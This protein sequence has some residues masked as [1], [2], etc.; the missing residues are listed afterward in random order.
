MWWFRAERSVLLELD[1]M[2]L[3]ESVGVSVTPGEQIGQVI[4]QW[5]E[6]QEEQWLLVFDNAVEPSSI[7]SYFPRCADHHV[8]VTS[9]NP[10]WGSE[11]HTLVLKTWSVEQS[12][13]FLSTRLPN[14]GEED[15]L[16]M[17]EALDGLPWALAQAASYIEATKETPQ[18]Y[19][20]LLDGIGTEEDVLDIQQHVS[21]ASIYEHSLSA[22]LSLAFGRL[23]EEAQLL[24]RLSA[25]ASPDPVPEWLFREAT[26]L[27]PEPLGGII[28]DD[29]KWNKAVSDL[30]SFGLVSRIRNKD[31]APA[32][33]LHRLTQYIVRKRLAV[34]V[35][36]CNVFQAMLGSACPRSPREPEHWPCYET[37]VQHIM[38]LEQFGESGHLNP[39]VFTHLLNN[40]S[41]FLHVRT[42]QYT[43]SIRMSRISIDVACKKLGPNHCNTLDGMSNLASSLSQLDEFNEARKLHERVLAARQSELGANHP[44]TLRSMGDLATILSFLDESEEARSLAER[45]L[46]MRGS[47]L[48]E[49]HP[50]TL[51]GM[52]NLA[53][54]LRRLGDLEGA[55]LLRERALEGYRCL[56][57]EEHPDTLKSMGNLAYVLR[58][59]GN[60][61]SARG[62]EYR[63][64]EGRRRM[65]GE[66]HPDTLKAKGNLAA[67]LLEEGEI[68]EAQEHL[69]DA[70]KYFL[71]VFGENHQDTLTTKAHLANVLRRRGRL[72]D[73]R[74]LQ[75]SVLD[76]RICTLGPEHALT[77]ASYHS[78]AETLRAR[79]DPNG[80]RDLE[81]RMT[82]ARKRTSE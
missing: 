26:G 61:S 2:R 47:A 49:Y 56:W 70:L 45:V 41:V 74:E 9:R 78:L 10:N 15:L 33:V 71:V 53:H 73:A 27:L 57:G 16:V 32:L 39:L 43:E 34:F 1:A 59:Q 36:D 48:G 6:Q 14:V 37:L 3:C 31:G 76:A 69:E 64:L 7:L 19:C 54:V 66:T 52:G 25:F 13:Q 29:S 24:L 40:V 50:D 80:T 60:H 8:I 18:R 21:S 58:C 75:E 51:M 42:A 81:Q 77:R 5:L 11:A 63:V 35:L 38:Q 55:R 23:S 22:G 68:E 44:D 46:E 20:Q 17:A 67:T 4:R 79:N 12:V 72:D 30:I 65:F 62:L 28:G 82:A